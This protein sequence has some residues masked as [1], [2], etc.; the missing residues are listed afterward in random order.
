MQEEYEEDRPFS[1]VSYIQTSQAYSDQHGGIEEWFPNNSFRTFIQGSSILSKYHMSMSTDSH[2][3]QLKDEIKELGQIL[4]LSD[5]ISTDMINISLHTYKK[6]S[7]LYKKHNKKKTKNKLF[8]FSTYWGLK[9]S[10]QLITH[11]TVA[12]ILNISPKIVCKALKEINK[13]VYQTDFPTQKLPPVS[14]SY[15]IQSLNLSWSY[16]DPIHK[17]YEEL[18]VSPDFNHRPDSLLAGILYLFSQETKK[19]QIC[20]LLNISETTIY[21]MYKKI[22]QNKNN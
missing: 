22:L 5:K 3:K 2:E 9:H 1:G 6:I 18:I 7:D 8:V 17:L 19:E 12:E 13:F 11:Q 10:G 15:Y 21:Q 20:K 4:S 16:L 14:F